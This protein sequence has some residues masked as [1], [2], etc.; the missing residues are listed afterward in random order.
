MGVRWWCDR[1]VVPGW[2]Q[3]AMGRSPEVTV[4]QV[5]VAIGKSVGFVSIMSAS[6]M[7]WMKAVVVFVKE[8][9]LVDR[10]IGER[11]K[12]SQEFFLFTS[13]ASVTTGVMITNVPPF[14]ANEDIKRELSCFRKLT[15]SI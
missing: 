2:S 8:K 7:K 9:S 12:V 11:I 4:E 1:A 15:G 13:L 3:F 6:R 14:I 5:L 10:L